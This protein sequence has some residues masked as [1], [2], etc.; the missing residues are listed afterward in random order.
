MKPRP[1]PLK[2]RRVAFS[3]HPSVDFF[4]ETGLLEVFLCGVDVADL[5]I[6]GIFLGAFLGA[7][8]IHTLSDAALKKAFGGFMILIGIKMA[9]LK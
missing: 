4:F 2:I 1:R 8:Y 9:F 6:A 7:N 5:K 3:S